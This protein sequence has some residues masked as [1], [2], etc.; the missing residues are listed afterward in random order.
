VGATNQYLNSLNVSNSTE[1]AH[2]YT[3]YNLSSSLI[4]N[5]VNPVKMAVGFPNQLLVTN[6]GSTASTWISMSGDSTMTSG[7]LTIA[8]DA[9]TTAKVLNASITPIKIN[10]GSANQIFQ[11]SSTLINNWVSMSGDATLTN[12]ALTITDGAISLAKLSNI[13]YTQSYPST[14]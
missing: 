5:S 10:L 12:G 13:Y 4:T 11:T 8:N 14:L 7:V 9:I 2:T 1:I 3:A 6:N